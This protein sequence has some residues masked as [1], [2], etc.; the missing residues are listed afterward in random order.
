MGYYKVIWI[1]VRLWMD[2][3]TAINRI[4]LEKLPYEQDLKIFSVNYFDGYRYWLWNML[5]VASFKN[6]ISDLTSAIIG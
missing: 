6:H 5:S 4:M 3:C 1:I 2:N